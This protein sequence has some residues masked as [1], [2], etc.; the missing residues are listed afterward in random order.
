MVHDAGA[1][2]EEITCAHTGLDGRG[3]VEPD[4]DPL[5]VLA[6]VPDPRKT[7]G[8]RHRLVT[9][10]AVSVCALTGAPTGAVDVTGRHLS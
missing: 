6:G 10:L 5:V 2:K 4:A 3:G 1:T 8:C 9:V 7:R